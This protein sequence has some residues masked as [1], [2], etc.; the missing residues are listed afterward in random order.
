MKVSL[1]GGEGAGGGS[2][3]ED[4]MGGGEAQLGVW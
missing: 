3:D 1:V 4:L 2:C